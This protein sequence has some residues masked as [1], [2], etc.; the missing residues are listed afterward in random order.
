VFEPPAAPQTIGDARYSAPQKTLLPLDWQLTVETLHK[1]AQRMNINQITFGAGRSRS[2]QHSPVAFTLIELLVVIAI[3]AILAGMLLPALA[4]AKAKATAVHCMGNLKQL[5]LVWTMYADDNNEYVAG[6]YWTEEQAKT[7]D[8]GNWVSGW[9]DPR[10]ANN[11]DNTNILLLLQQKYGVLGP[12]A[13]S[14]DVYRCMASKVRAKEGGTSYP[15][16]RTVSM[17][18][19][20]GFRT[21]PWN[22]GFLTFHKTT[23]IRGFGASDA[24]VFM[25]ERDDSI[26]DG[27]FAIDMVANQIPNV[28]AGYHGGSGGVT[29]ADGHAEIHRWRSP[30]VLR[31]QQMGTQTKKWEFMPVAATNPDLIWL[32][33]HATVHQ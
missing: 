7:P 31:T 1:T 30:E 15:V 13:Q 20:M 29:F 33:A 6:N 14:K 27:E 24:L 19:W 25:D 3:I 12:Y 22:D 4:K 32:R 18:V 16:V 21:Q 26:D 23:D 8:K 9:L 10:T 2:G 28:P 11:T 5:Q 17:S